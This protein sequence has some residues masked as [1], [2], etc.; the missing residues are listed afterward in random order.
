MP[1]E[2][3]VDSSSTEESQAVAE[4][5]PETETVAEEPESAES[6]TAE[7]EASS[8]PVEGESAEAPEA[9]QPV[10]RS[11]FETR[12]R[13]LTGK[14]KDLERKLAESS[15]QGESKSAELEEPKVP[16]L[17]DYDDLTKFGA[18]VAAFPAKHKAWAME[19]AKR[20]LEQ[21]AQAD[22]LEKERAVTAESWA[23][24]EKD[25]KKRVPDFNTDEAIAE[26]EPNQ[27]MSGFFVES[28][29]G[30]DVLAYLQDNPKEA[31]RI[32]GISNPFSAHRELIKIEAAVSERIQGK[33]KPAPK[34]PGYIKGTGASPAKGKDA[35][36]VLYG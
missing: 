22:A 36:D 2:E 19:S 17:E 5:E 6:A 30:P 20:E 11:N 13:K 15:K 7:G 27:V 26:V 21:K 35:A 31:E 16:V 24:R 3:R 8:E 4:P 28:P 32:K 18:D 34:V 25:T 10:K 33:S 14:I 9:S 1:D 29:I 12:V 23:K